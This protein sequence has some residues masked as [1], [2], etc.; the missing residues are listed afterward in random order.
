MSEHDVLVEKTGRTVVVTLNRA[1]ARNSL[2]KPVV[3]ALAAA[4][5][6]AGAD[7]DVRCVVLGGAGGHFCAG[8]DLRRTFAEDPDIMDHLD[9]YMDAFHSLIRAIVRCPKPTIARMEGAAVGFGA[10]M[11][12]ACDLRIAS[13]TAYLQEKFVNI[14]LMPDG[15]GTFWLPRLIGTARAMKAML[16]SDK[17]E[18]KELDALGLLTS[19]VPPDELNAATRALASRIENG[20]PLA[21]AALKAAVYASL[22]DVEAALKREREGQLRLLRSQ[23]VIEGVMA[24]SQKRVPDFKGQ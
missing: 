4:I 23:D 7:A 2:T 17:V 24:W 15:G 9:D 22:G 14:G 21:Y 19:V 13:T 5:E 11:A 20:P 6:G 8:A 18:A 16:L 12:L 3:M 1:E 10:D